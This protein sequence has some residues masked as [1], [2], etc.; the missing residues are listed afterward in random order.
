MKRTYI[1]E[2]IP[3][4]WFHPKG[5]YKVLKR[6]WHR[7]PNVSG[8]LFA[9]LT[10]DRELMR[11][12]GLGPS[13]AFDLT[14]DRIRRILHRLRN[15]VEWEGKVYRIKGA[16]CTK[17]EFHADE[18]GWPHYHLI[19]LTRRYVPKELLEHLWSYGF[20]DLRRIQNQDFHYLLKYVCKSGKV[21]EWV[22]DRN[23]LR[24][25]TP[26]RGFLAPEDRKKVK[27]PTNVKKKRKSYTLRQRI[28]KWEKLVLHVVEDTETGE[29]KCCE[30]TIRDTFQNLFDR[31]IIEVVRE[32]RYLG[33][34]VIQITHNSQL[35]P[36]MNLDIMNPL[37]I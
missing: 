19:W 9:T 27:E 5:I 18:E 23:R 17:V 36:W 3:C 37:M 21:P 30:M 34:R 29:K 24:I 8:S 15:G 32:G 16:Y 2:H 10:I 12:R 11:S 6:F 26:S 33:D 13:E 35:K 7:L 28:L 14:R 4:S 20:V 1:K 31:L 22:K 25:F